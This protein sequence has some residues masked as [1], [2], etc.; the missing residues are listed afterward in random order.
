MSEPSKEETQ[1]I[2]KIFSEAYNL[3]NKTNFKWE[4]TFSYQP[5]SYPDCDFILI[6]DATK[7]ALGV[8]LTKAVAD[9]DRE[10]VRWKN[11]DKVI[12]PLKKRLEA[13]NL[14]PISIFINFENQPKTNEE[15]SKLIFWLDHII[16]Q[17]SSYSLGSYFYTYEKRFDDQFTFKIKNFVSK[18]SIRP[19]ENEKP[20]KINM[21]W[22][23]AKEEPEPWLDDEQRAMKAID[24]K[25]RKGLSSILLVDS[26]TRPIDDLYIP[27]I[28]KSAAGS[29]ID[30]IWILDNF[31]SIKRAL[32]IR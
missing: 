6:D 32:R 23:T 2:A 16:T 13:Q 31:S 26:G 11:A 14:P 22:M 20:G 17:K 12:S 10:F 5:K 18:L 3:I 24:N 28:K 9:P 1:Q 19:I 15:I 27:M 25:E 30:E 7:K 21:M 8:Q 4:S 29:K